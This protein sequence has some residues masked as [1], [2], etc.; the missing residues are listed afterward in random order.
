MSRVVKRRWPGANQPGLPRR[1]RAPCDYEAY[2][3]DPLSDRRIMLDADVAADV[4]EASSAIE[5]LNQVVSTLVDSEALA[6][7]LLRAESVASSRIEGLEIGPRRLLLAEASDDRG[8]RDLTAKE[9]L[10]NIEAMRSSIETMAGAITVEDILGTHRVLLE[11]TS[12]AEH[13][14]RLRSEQNW[15]GGNAYNPCGAAFVPPPPEEVGRLMHDLV[16]FSERT[17]IPPVAQAAI[18]HAQFETIH[19]FVDGNGRVGRAVIHVILRRHGTA[20]RIVPPIS[21]ILATRASDYIAGL[22]ATRYRGAPSSSS[23]HEGINRWVAMFAAACSRAVQD[24]L[25]FESRIEEIQRGWLER[26]GKVRRGSAVS[27]LVE[28]IPRTPVLSVDVA[29]SL[30]ERSFQQANVAM[31][32]LE[33]AGIIRQVSTRKRGRAFEVPDIITAFTALERQLASPAGDTRSSRPARRV[34]GRPR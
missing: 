7:L 34:P 29:A 15:I 33:Q 23:A 16:A 19:P 26:L 30:I 12:L 25:A 11:G 20:P 14:G 9:V 28:R 6:R 22:T 8:S 5:R 27:L 24:A 17:D 4:A 21:L 18:A 2:V 31:Q 1:H 13:A 10:A 32:R 3:P